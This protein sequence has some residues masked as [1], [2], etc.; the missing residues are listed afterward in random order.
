[1]ESLLYK[2]M[3]I[4]V[5]FVCFVMILRYPVG[6]STID[7]NFLIIKLTSS[8]LVELL[9]RARLS[10]LIYGTYLCSFSAK[11]RRKFLR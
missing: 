2:V 1:M 10:P 5:E 11:I 3:I 7:P 6:W 4:P 8:G 9:G